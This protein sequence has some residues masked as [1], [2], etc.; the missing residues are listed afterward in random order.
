MSDS[1]V[2]GKNN[3]MELVN[4]NQERV[5][6]V[7]DDGRILV[8]G[9]EAPD[10]DD[11]RAFVAKTF[12]DFLAQFKP[13]DMLQAI[14]AAQEAQQ[15]QFNL[16]PRAMADVDKS[17]NTKDLALNLY[18]E[19]S[20]LAELATNY[21]AHILRRSRPSKTNVADA[22]VDVL[23]LAVAVAQ[24]HGVTA[25]EVYQAFIRK[26]KVIEDRARGERLALERGTRVF[27]SDIDGC[28]ADLSEWESSLK[29]I[30]GDGDFKVRML[31][32]L[33]EDYYLNGGFR[34]LPAIPGAAAALAKIK[35]AGYRIVLITARPAWQY[36]RLY[37]DTIE[38]LAE[39]GIQHDLILF[40]KDKAEAIYER[41][42]P[43]QPRYFVEDREK[44]AIELANIGVPVLFF[45][46]HASIPERPGVKKVSGWE[47]IVKE[48]LSGK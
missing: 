15:V 12:R 28:I 10:D 45:G 22:V 30:G 26:S 9:K 42:H 21:K 5:L 8:H 48:V 23:K 1:S 31:E 38:W 3:I 29:K 44:H 25:S 14:W 11:G 33:K 19:V 46:A 16:D 20:E 39:Q 32:T 18:E 35:E 43:A 4:A 40:N 13:V 2:L 47:D 41:I 7:T 27:V 6:V 37:A 34:G 36:K 17:A 24:M